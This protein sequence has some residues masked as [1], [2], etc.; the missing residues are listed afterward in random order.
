MFRLN[1]SPQ[2]INWSERVTRITYP[3]TTSKHRTLIE[4]VSSYRLHIK[5]SVTVTECGLVVPVLVK[6]SCSKFC[7]NPTEGSV[8]DTRPQMDR[9]SCY[10]RCWFSYFVKNA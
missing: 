2:K 8:S 7:L 9:H 3:G 5:R 4:K 10:I 6:I 1:D